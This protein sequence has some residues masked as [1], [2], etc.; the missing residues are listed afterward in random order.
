VH[1]CKVTGG[2]V[3]APAAVKDEC[4]SSNGG[5][6]AP[7]L[8]NNAAAPTAVLELPLLTARAPAPTPVLKLRGIQ[9]DRQPSAICFKPRWWGSK[10]IAPSAVVGVAPIR[11][12]GWRWRG[13][14]CRCGRCCGCCGRGRGGWRRCRCR[15]RIRHRDRA[16][17]SQHA[18]CGVQ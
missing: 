1:Q 13:R 17:H 10:R 9:S 12:S 2:R 6:C 8:S 18:P 3:R 11:Y 7:V 16:C 14:G 4:I 5:V 15:R